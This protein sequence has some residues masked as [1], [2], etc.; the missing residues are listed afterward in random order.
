MTPS[1]PQEMICFA[2]SSFDTPN[3]TATWTVKQMCKLACIYRI[4]PRNKQGT[5]ASALPYG[6]ICG[7]PR[8]VSSRSAK[9]SGWRSPP[10]V[11]IVFI[12]PLLIRSPYLL[13]STAVEKKQRGKKNTF[14]CSGEETKR[15]EKQR[16]QAKPRTH[17]LFLLLCQKPYISLMWEMC[18]TTLYNFCVSPHYIIYC[19]SRPGAVHLF[20]VGNVFHHII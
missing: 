19:V 12:H 10:I 8:P 5:C 13:R 4:R 14:Y 20:H 15:K 18:F 9:Q 16:R 2:C 3:P 1:A 6:F 7:W 17:F 11:P